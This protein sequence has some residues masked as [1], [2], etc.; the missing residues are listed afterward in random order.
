MKQENVRTVNL[1]QNRRLK[2]ER[3]TG[4]YKTEKS[5]DEVA[6]FSP[7]TAVSFNIEQFAPKN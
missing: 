4:K 5:N 2:N 1:T 3:E 7:T 6:F